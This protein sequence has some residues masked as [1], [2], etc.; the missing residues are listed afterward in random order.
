MHQYVQWEVELC[1]WLDFWP[2]FLL[3]FHN[4]HH[5]KRLGVT[6]ILGGGEQLLIQSYTPNWHLW[7]E[8]HMT[9]IFW[10]AFYTK[11]SSYVKLLWVKKKWVAF[12]LQEYM[13][14]PRNW[15]THN[16][17]AISCRRIFSGNRKYAER[18]QTE[19]A[20]VQEVWT[21]MGGFKT[22]YL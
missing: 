21:L 1:V 3:K 22:L 14:S 19:F 4:C 18:F 12:T 8:M 16:Q 10:T 9:F 15:E 13:D 6:A 7:C 17:R 20:Q 11:R 5:H 2:G